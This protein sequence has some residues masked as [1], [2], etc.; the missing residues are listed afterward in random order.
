[1]LTKFFRISVPK[2]R[3]MYKFGLAFVLS[4]F[5]IY[6]E[7]P[8]IP[9]SSLDEISWKL[10]TKP[11]VFGDAIMLDCRLPKNSCCNRYTRRWLGGHAFRLLVMDGVSA[12]P[13]KYSEVF[14]SETRSSKLTI[15]AL[16]PKDV[17]IPYECTYGFTT[18]IKELALSEDM[19]E[20]YPYKPYDVNVTTVRGNIL[21]VEIKL[22]PVYPKPN[23]T[24]TLD[25]T[26]ISDFMTITPVLRGLFYVVIIIVRYK[27]NPHT[28]PAVFKLVCK[29]GTK[30]L[31]IHEQNNVTC[32]G[33]SSS[34]E[35]LLSGLKKTILFT[36]IAFIV[37]AVLVTLSFFI[38]YKHCRKNISRRN[39]PRKKKKSNKHKMKR[40]PQLI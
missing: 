26:N 31:D 38:Y 1:M 19:F 25:G 18:Y 7:G 40:L 33:D 8:S 29:I 36:A 20:S 30:L 27:M 24:A 10:S 32:C 9:N 37:F 11:A 3:H 2:Y 14:N 34:G 16:N 4:L 28:S 22:Q 13:K 12:S 15:N 39:N 5:A 35:K 23:C 21:T 6:V 17:N